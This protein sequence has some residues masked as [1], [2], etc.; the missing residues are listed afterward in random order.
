M[1][2]K[3]LLLYDHDEFIFVI[4]MTKKITYPK[5]NLASKAFEYF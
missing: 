1:I 2:F 5:P 4:F 3:Y